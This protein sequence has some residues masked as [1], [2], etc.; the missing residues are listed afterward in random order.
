MIA[1]AFMIYDESDL[2]VFQLETLLYLCDVVIVLADNP[3]E[4]VETILR[5]Y[6]QKNLVELIINKKNDNFYERDERGDNERLLQKARELGA[7]YCFFTRADE[8]VAP[9]SLNKVKS[10]IDNYDSS[11]VVQFYRYDLWYNAHSYRNKSSDQHLK[12]KL[13]EGNIPAIVY[14]YIFPILNNSTYIPH[15]WP[16][17]PN[18]HC[19]VEPYP[20]QQMKHILYD[21]VFIIHYGY[22]RPDIAIKKGKFY[23]T[24]SNVTGNVWQHDMQID[25]KTFIEEYGMGILKRK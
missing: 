13:L 16:A 17:V 14:G 4:Q 3:T 25:D 21:D 5:S 19:E 10:I 1:G 22:Y 24:K 11:Y 20:C 9:K 15:G 18:F 23:N 7:N 2:V 6:E 12:G 8:I